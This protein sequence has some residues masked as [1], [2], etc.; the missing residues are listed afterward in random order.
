MI[1]VEAMACAKPVISINKMGP[2]ETIIHKKTGFLAEV[3][4]EIKLDQEWV[5]PHMGFN[6]RK[7]IQFDSPKTFAYRASIEDL[8]KYTLK[9]LTEPKLCKTMGQAG[10][11]HVLKNLDYKIIGKKISDITKD[12]LKL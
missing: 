6:E 2:S 1:Q 7:I 4:E 9:L 5:Y 12:R 10:R 3:A 8:R 11:E